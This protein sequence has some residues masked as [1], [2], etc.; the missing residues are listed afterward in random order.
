MFLTVLLS[1][2]AIQLH[3]L[4]LKLFYIIYLALNCLGF[5]YILKFLHNKGLLPWIWILLLLNFSVVIQEN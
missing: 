4:G 1:M 3:T 5:K 2:V